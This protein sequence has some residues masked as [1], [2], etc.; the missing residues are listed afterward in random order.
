MATTLKARAG[1]T[2][3]H[4]FEYRDAAGEL[5]DT[6]TTP[7]RFQLKS[8]QGSNAILL[9]TQESEVAGSILL[10]TAAGQW[11]LTLDPSLTARLPSTVVWELEIATV[12]NKTV[13]TVESGVIK[14][15]PQEV[16]NT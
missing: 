11:T 8:L 12:D 10:K 1:S 5:I 14:V 16:T 4:D 13:T 6:T 3:T 9:N 7:A 2:F 15:E